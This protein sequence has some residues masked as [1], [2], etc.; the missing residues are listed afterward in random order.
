MGEGDL[1]LTILYVGGTRCSQQ[2]AEA[3]DVIGSLREVR[4]LVA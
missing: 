2:H 4:L 3:D 1:S